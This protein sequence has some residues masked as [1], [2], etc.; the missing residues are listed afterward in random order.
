MSPRPNAFRP[1]PFN[2]A[3]DAQWI[4][5]THWVNLTDACMAASLDCTNMPIRCSFRYFEETIG[6]KRFTR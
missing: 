4:Y 6:L 2:A 1:L 3:M 5:G